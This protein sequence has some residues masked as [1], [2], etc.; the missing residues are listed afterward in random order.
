[1]TE[2]YSSIGPYLS[3]RQDTG[4]SRAF[5]N[6]IG[7][8]WFVTVGIGIL[9]AIVLVTALGPLV[10]TVSPLKTSRD[11]LFPPDA[12]HLLGTD[13]YGRDVLAR[14]L[15]AFR[16]DLAI[17]V[18]AVACSVTL[19]TI[20]GSVSGYLG[21][22]VDA[23]LMR[24]IDVIQ[25]FPMLLLALVL[26]ATLGIGMTT[27]ILVT[28]I[29]N[30]P[31]YAK[32]VRG[33]VLSKK[34]QEYVDAARSSGCTE[35][36]ILVRHLLPNTT[37]AVVVQ[38][39]MNLG[40]AILNVAGLSFL[41][42]GISPPTPDLGVMIADGAMYISQGLWWMSVYPG[43]ALVLAVCAFNLLGDGLQDGLDPRRQ[44]F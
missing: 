16:I 7:R 5:L 37:G 17:A 31:M 42:I 44:K 32:L 26:A 43:L 30:I 29:I 35:V 14:L 40:W 41:G 13:Q 22:K 1:M 19:G 6:L 25:T 3:A 24:V 10:Y 9:L 33:E 20:I 34:R 39:S 38:A 8:N 23:L 11:I 12:L 2:Q 18:L 28:I 15:V 21:G 27:V 36:R 4:R